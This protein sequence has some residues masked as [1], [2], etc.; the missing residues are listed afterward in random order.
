MKGGKKKG[1]RRCRKSK[2]QYFFPTVVF[3]GGGIEQSGMIQGGKWGQHTEF[4]LSATSFFI[5]LQQ[6]K[7]ETN[8]GREIKNEKV[9][10]QP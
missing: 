7:Q 9:P 6:D 5:F 8:A 1:M 10:D 4:K 3:D 2:S